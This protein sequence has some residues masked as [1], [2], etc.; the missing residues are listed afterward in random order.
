M[1]SSNS[2]RC[3]CSKKPPIAVSASPVSGGLH[4]QQLSKEDLQVLKPMKIFHER[5]EPLR[6]NKKK[7]LLSSG[8]SVIAVSSMEK[9]RRC[10]YAARRIP[11]HM[12]PSVDNEELANYLDS[13]AKLDHPHICK[14][15]E[16]FADGDCWQ[17]IYEK[18]H[19]IPLFE[20]AWG[21][22]DGFDE[23][24]V[25]ILIRQVAM[26]LSLAHKQGV[27]HGRLVPS[28]LLLE[29]G[30]INNADSSL[31][32][33]HL[34]VCDIGQGFILQ[35][36]IMESG[37]ESRFGYVAPELARG[38]FNLRQKSA[39]A[40]VTPEG[41]DKLDV[42]A[43][44]AMTYH[45]LTGQAP[46]TA[47]DLKFAG[48]E[49]HEV[50]FAP[51]VWGKFTLDAQ[52]AVVSMLMLDDC[53]RISASQ[54]LKHPWIKVAT[55]TLPKELMPTLLENMR[56]N[57]AETP[58][59][60]AVLRVLVALLPKEMREVQDM[61]KV[62]RCLDADDDGV[63]T[64]EELSQEIVKCTTDQVDLT[65]LRQSLE[66]MRLDH[67]PAATICV[68]D[69]LAIAFCQAED[70][71]MDNMWKAFNAFDRDRNGIIDESEIEEVVHRLEGGL[72]GKGKAGGICQ[73]VLADV[74]ATIGPGELLNF[75]RFVMMMSIPKGLGDWSKS[76][77]KVS[78][79]SSEC[80]WH[81][82]GMD[83]YGVR[84]KEVP[85][86]ELVAENNFQPISPVC[87]YRNAAR[88]AT[89]AG[90]QAKRSP[91]CSSSPRGRATTVVRQGDGSPRM[92][93]RTS[94]APGASPRR[95][96]I[97]GQQGTGS[98]RSSPRTT[99]VGSQMM[100]TSGPR[101]TV[102]GSP[103]GPMNPRKTVLGQ[104][105]LFIDESTTDSRQSVV[106]SPRGPMSP[107]KTILGATAVSPRTSSA[108][109]ENTASPRSPNSTKNRV[110]SAKMKNST[111]STKKS[112]RLNTE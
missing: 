48:A 77:A 106:A 74:E 97:P 85:A 1:G 4:K 39:H 63:L 65:S 8:G 80:L 42:F 61:E 27:V 29:T 68:E 81:K 5:Y 94:G 70:M 10:D 60:S 109:A 19:N 91:R 107:R 15:I 55:D 13:L 21:N 102:T 41:S 35:P 57:L 17:L 24:T 86:W 58:F 31:A 32:N 88:A 103:R 96:V 45:M 111:S 92:S 108:A 100:S 9:T 6:E 56:V 76:M 49:V 20:Y 69:F 82:C 14:F 40:L 18:C 52:D 104:G 101:K 79:Q 54:L 59:R 84:K 33:L 12:A 75:D 43:L 38:E 37:K 16:A 110:E 105:G 83:A 78:T 87:P 2:A 89:A 11:R 23:A 44:G 26:G 71:S 112:V 51:E 36:S 73:V 64:V 7:V 47:Q 67:D 50:C 53:E 90:R 34:K 46:F 3:C 99:Q 28:S 93:P 62:F 30:S 22:E 72:R 25:A 98:P 95:T 66:C